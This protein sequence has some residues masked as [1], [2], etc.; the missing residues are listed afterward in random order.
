L[1]SVP[2]EEYHGMS[3]PFFAFHRSSFSIGAREIIA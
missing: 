3:Q 2:Y 1:N